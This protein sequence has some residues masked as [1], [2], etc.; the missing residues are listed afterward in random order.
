MK[1]SI[2]IIL[3]LVLWSCNSSQTK[4]EA[5]EQAAP[6]QIENVAQQKCDHIIDAFK[7]LATMNP[8]SDFTE[9]M[10]VLQQNE[11]IP[12]I[13]T[14]DQHQIVSH[15]NI[16]KMAGLSE[17]SSKQDLA[18]ALLEMDKLNDPIEIPVMEGVKNYI[19]YC[20]PSQL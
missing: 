4:Q 10:L 18:I 11:Q 3:T 12:V 5:K 6:K 8:D 16:E 17:N 15:K 9:V 7:Q 13:L 2:L 14:D 20:K 1:S 19:H